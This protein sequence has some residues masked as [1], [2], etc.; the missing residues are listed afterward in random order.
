MLSK[1]KRALEHLLVAG[2]VTDMAHR[3]GRSRRLIL[4]YHNVTPHGATSA[5]ETSL[6]VGQAAFAEQLESLAQVARVVELDRILDPAPGRDRAIHVAITFDDAYRGA[7][8]AGVEELVQ[9]ALPATIFAAPALLGDRPMWWDALA[10]AGGGQIPPDVRQEAL[11]SCAGRKH[12]VLRW[13]DS[14][15]FRL[16][17]MP[18]H[19]RTATESELQRA[20][21]LP[22]ISVGSHSW[23]HP[24]LSR[25]DAASLAEELTR[26]KSWL[27]SRYAS[28]VPWLAYPYGVSS[29]AAERAAEAAGYVGAVRMDGGPLRAGGILRYRLPRL[30]VPAGLSSNGFRLRLAGIRCR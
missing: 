13:A 15:G 21:C 23:S 29:A 2:G 16:A 17:D 7:V 18:P 12:E 10:Q 1:L 19:A 30:N 11:D 28:F 25:L 22:G 6:H 8:T 20:V 3:F 9:R 27:E 26:S 14:H 24:N 4:A 5:G